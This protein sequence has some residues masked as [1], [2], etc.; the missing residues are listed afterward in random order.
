MNSIFNPDLIEESN[1]FE[2]LTVGIQELNDI[3]EVDCSENGSISDENL[4]KR[5][6]GRAY[7]LFKTYSSFKEAAGASTEEPALY[8]DA[9]WAKGIPLTVLAHF[10]FFK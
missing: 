5:G 9:C 8:E 2:S 10:Y 1:D 3:N 6:K 4:R 7:V